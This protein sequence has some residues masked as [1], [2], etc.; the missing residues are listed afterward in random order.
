MN[1]LEGIFKCISAIST[2]LPPNNPATHCCATHSC[3]LAHPYEC[4]KMYF[5]ILKDRTAHNCTGNSLQ[6]FIKEVEVLLT[7]LFGEQNTVMIL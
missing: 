3:T 4:F 7:L 6:H 5:K 1:Y 2:T